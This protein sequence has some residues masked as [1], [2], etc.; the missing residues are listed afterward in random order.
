VEKEEEEKATKN[1]TQKDIDVTAENTLENT[2]DP[3]EDK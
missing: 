2:H 3:A 1:T